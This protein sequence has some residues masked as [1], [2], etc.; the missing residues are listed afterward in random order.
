MTWEFSRDKYGMVV[1]TLG[2]RLREFEDALNDAV[3]SRAPKGHPEGLSVYWVDRALE[4]LKDAKLGEWF[5]Q[6]NGTALLLSEDGVVAIPTYEYI[7]YETASSGLFADSTM[8]RD[9]FEAGIA[10]WRR[11]IVAAI[12]SDPAA[13]SG[14]LQRNPR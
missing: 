1:V 2:D 6:G 10:A 7:D 9:Q 3:T 4:D 14:G 8:P 5:C 12:A 11:E 13:P